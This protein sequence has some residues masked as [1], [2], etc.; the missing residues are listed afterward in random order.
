MLAELGVLVAVRV[1]FL[2]LQPQLR[3]CQVE[4]PVGTQF[5]VDVLAVRRRAFDRAGHMLG[6]EKTLFELGFTQYRGFIPA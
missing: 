5:V 2:V 4:F 3:E 1:L 6:G